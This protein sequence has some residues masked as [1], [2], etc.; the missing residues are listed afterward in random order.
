[1]APPAAPVAPAILAFDIDGTVLGADDRPVPGIGDALRELGAAGVRLVPATGRPLHRAL[2]AAAELGVAPA[3]CIA[4]HGALV[5]DLV[6]GE[7]LRHLALPEELAAGLAGRCLAAGL[8]V[9]LYVG[10]E[11]RDLSPGAAPDRGAAAAAGARLGIAGDGGLELRVAGVTRLVVA[12]DPARVTPALPELAGAAAA[13]LRVEPVRPGVVVALPGGA[14]KGEG[15]RLV[16]A[17][18][19]VPRDRVVACGDAAND[20]SLL[21]AAGTGIAVGDAPPALRSAAAAT[22]ARE[23]L[24]AALRAAFARLG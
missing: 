10:D 17:H 9:S 14:D 23:D 13:G 8:D 2:A 16:A 1:M 21:R 22:V 5:V 11:R 20:V 18:L 24:P 7:W 6:G 3:A 15:L 4:Y 19:A 12:G